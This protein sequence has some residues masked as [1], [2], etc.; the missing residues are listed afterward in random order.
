VLLA[1]QFHFENN[2]AVLCDDG[3]PENTFP[4]IMRMLR[5]NPKLNVFVLHDASPRGCMLAHKL[6]TSPEWFAGIGQVI[7]VGLRPAHARFFPGMAEKN[8]VPLKITPTHGIDA[9]EAKW[10]SRWRL[11]MTVVRPEQLIKRLYR[12]MTG[13]EQGGWGAGTGNGG[14]TG[15][16]DVIYFGTDADTS[17]GG[18]DSFG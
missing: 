10:L 6:R 8:P 1:N 7:D 5:K 16:A 11:E 17:D 2:C 18:G 15:G 4:I 14:S 9:A 12:A 13:V 3:Y